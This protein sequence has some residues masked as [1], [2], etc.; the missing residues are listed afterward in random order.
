MSKP[1]ELFEIR[2][3]AD[4]LNLAFRTLLARREQIPS[5]DELESVFRDFVDVDG[6]FVL[7][8]Q[9]DAHEARMFELFL[10]ALFRDWGFSRDVSHSRP[11]FVLVR[12]EL[13]AC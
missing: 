4:R 7:K 13:H 11:D 3:A 10:F 8:F 2:I 1:R 12:D 9:S 6:D 5:R